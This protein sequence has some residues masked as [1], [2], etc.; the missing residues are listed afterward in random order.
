[1]AFNKNTLSLYL[2]TDRPLALGRDL[3]QVVSQAVRGGVTLVQ[4]REK[5]ATTREFVELGRALKQ[6]LGPTGV[7]LL[8][9]DRLDIAQAIDADGV[10]LGQSDMPYADARAILGPDKIIGVSIENDAQAAEAEGQDVDYIALSPVYLTDTK[11]DTSAALGLEG[12]RR[13]S[14]ATSHPV[15]AIGGMNARTAADVIRAGADGIAVVSAIMSA[16]DPEAAAA[17]LLQIVRN[18]KKHRI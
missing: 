14:A 18:A 10:H 13:I 15:C 7:P 8:I 1:M 9:N 4:L 6:I 3:L 2:V 17:G 5:H 16:P 11:T 12:V